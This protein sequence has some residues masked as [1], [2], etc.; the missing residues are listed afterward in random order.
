MT[1]TLNTCFLDIVERRGP[2]AA[3]AVKR[4]GAWQQ[5]SFDW[6]FEQVSQT[7][8]GLLSIGCARGDRVAILSENRPE[9]ATSDFAA[10]AAGIVTVPLYTTLVPAQMAYILRD[11]GVRAV[12][13]STMEHLRTILAVRDSVPSIEKVVVFYPEG[14]DEDDLV[15]SLGTLQAAGT[16]RAREEFEA[17]SRAAHPEDTVTIVYTSGTTGDPK[18]VVLTHRA[19]GVGTGLALAALAAFGLVGALVAGRRR[20]V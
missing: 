14:L 2:H 9:W 7:A 5:H 20:M 11:A 6:A 18:G 1:A 12:L 19:R 17:L 15:I 13:V 16:S 8:F 3:F 10:M 4:L